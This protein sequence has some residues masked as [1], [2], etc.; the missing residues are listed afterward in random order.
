VLVIISILPESLRWLI[1]NGRHDEAN[2]VISLF[3]SVNRRSVSSA[4]IVDT[5]NIE[6][7]G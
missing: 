5:R 3:M 2:A 7:V 4:G 6:L 1:L